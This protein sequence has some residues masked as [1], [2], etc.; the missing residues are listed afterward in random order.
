MNIEDLPR[1]LDI[2]LDR[3]NDRHDSDNDTN[4]DYDNGDNDDN[5]NDDNDNIDN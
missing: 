4:L 1:A 5:G 2:S 3:V